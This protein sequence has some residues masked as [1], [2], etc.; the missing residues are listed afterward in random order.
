MKKISKVQRSHATR[1]GIAAVLAA[2]TPAFAQVTPP[3]AGQTLRE[4]QG[5]PAAPVQRN[6]TS[7]LVPADADASADPGMAFPVRHVRIEGNVQIG[8]AELLALAAPLQGRAATLG[9]LRQ[10]AARITALYRERGFI[11]ARAFVPAQ[12]IRDGEVRIAVLEGSLTSTSVINKSIIST[13]SLEAIPAAQALTGKVIQAA[14]SDREL[15][16]MADLPGAGA[17]NGVLR[18]GKEVGTSDMFITVDPGK[19]KEGQVS[20]DNFGNRYTGQ[21][22]LNANVDVNSPLNIGDRLSLRGTVTDERLLYGQLAYD[23][24]ANGDGWRV[25]ANLASSSYELGHEFSKLDAQGTSNTAGLYTSYPALRG[26]NA[27]IWLRAA[28]DY[29]KLKDEIRSASTVIDKHVTAA[30]LGAYGDLSDA[31]GGGAYSTWRATYT[32]GKLDIDSASALLIDQAG[33]RSDGNYRKF[34]LAATRL[35]AIT[36]LTSAFFSFAGQ[37]AG[38]N[39]DSSEKFVLGG[40][41]GVRAYPQGEAVGDEG[42]L[43][44]VE[45]RH[46]FAAGVQAS[47]FYDHGHVDYNRRAFAAGA[48]DVTLKGYGLSA[49]VRYQLYEVKATVAWRSGEAALSAPDRNPRLWLSA[50]RSF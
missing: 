22:R 7:L 39:L 47:V 29:R 21:L 32:A 1:W 9:E 13:P 38:K 35:Q 34:E 3:N 36:P 48:N 19:S 25:G 4:L 50:R 31:L 16:L 41:Y 18:P 45:V 5:Q 42:W 6:A 2:G 15:L 44:N 10:V 40:I 30:T 46:D 11:V 37:W 24:P 33:P 26:L 23:L 20:L 28:L 14:E 49:A 27:N 43:A 17:V 12:E 8:S